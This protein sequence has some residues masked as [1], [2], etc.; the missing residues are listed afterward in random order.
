MPDPFSY[1]RFPGRPAAAFAFMAIAGACATDLDRGDPAAVGIIQEAIAEHGGDV[2]EGREILF[3]FRGTDFRVIREGGPFVY[4][5]SYRD[6]SGR[7]VREGM[8]N[9]GVWL[10]LDGARV[11]VPPEEERRIE[12]ALNST[13]YFGFLP[14]RLDD[15][16]VVARDLG[17]AEIRGEPYRVV[18]VTFREEGGG[19]DW[20]DR[21][22][23]WF[24][25]EDRTLDYF[26]YRY[27]RDGGGTRFRE[28]VDRRSVDGLLVQDYVNYTAREG[29]EDIV[30]Y[31][32]LLEAGGEDL[33]VVS[34][35][36]LE[37]VR[38]R[39]LP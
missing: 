1:P 9:E 17:D 10:E 35:V 3:E 24:H 14:I 12:S 20:Q 33:E 16:S 6:A 38:V 30:D 29:I 31:P 4:E 2:F 7:M 39:P 26:A 28:A 11:P 34:I 32:G 19:E 21:F 25:A 22:V 18:E 15:P 8:E 13:V 36:A 23:H 27:H 5:R 37:G